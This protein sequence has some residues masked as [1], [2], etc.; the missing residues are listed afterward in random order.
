VSEFSERD[1]D[2]TGHARRGGT[3]CPLAASVATLYCA[4]G[5]P[6]SGE[7]ASGVSV[8]N[9]RAGCCGLRCSWGAARFAR[10]GPRTGETSVGRPR[11]LPRLTPAP[12][13][14]CTA[15]PLRSA[16]PSAGETA[17]VARSEV[18]PDRLSSGRRGTCDTSDT[19]LIAP[20][21][22]AFHS[23]ASLWKASRSIQARRP[24]VA[25]RML[26]FSGGRVPRLGRAL[27]SAPRT[28]ATE[29]RSASPQSAS[30]LTLAS[31]PPR[32][33]CSP[34]RGSPVRESQPLRLGIVRG[35]PPAPAAQRCGATPA[36]RPTS[37]ALPHT[38]ASERE[39][40]LG[41]GA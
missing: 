20:R 30:H 9:P 26:T 2:K 25:G 21:G 3:V 41:H 13:S 18:L 31:G 23:P 29:R 4:H 22:R 15:H 35:D 10:G 37:A 8:S 7:Q 38:Y 6:S 1:R 40:Q 39:S 36:R 16:S 19:T 24:V 34:P 17:V 11:G 27:V 14:G 33:G 28:D 12:H 32:A 5:V